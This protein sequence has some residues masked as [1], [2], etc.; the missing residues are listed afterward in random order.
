MI[1]DKQ[2]RE[3]V[4]VATEIEIEITMDIMQVNR[5]RAILDL[6]EDAQDW[7]DMCI[8]LAGKEDAAGNIQEGE[9]LARKALH[10]KEYIESL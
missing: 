8:A 2:L 6:K 5:E 7:Y 1:D 10:R 9:R 3:D 4:Q